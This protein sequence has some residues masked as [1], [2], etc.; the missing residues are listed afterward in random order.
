[1]GN[2]TNQ[3]HE[4]RTSGTEEPSHISPPKNPLTCLLAMKKKRHKLGG[5]Y[6]V[7]SNVFMPS[8]AFLGN[9]Q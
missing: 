1:L 7:G 6:T 8:M 4:E 3:G 2:P 5:Y 9:E